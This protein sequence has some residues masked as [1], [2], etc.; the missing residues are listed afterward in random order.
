M[1]RK[2]SNREK[3][4][5]L[6][7]LCLILSFI[8]QLI[9]PNKE[10]EYQDSLEVKENIKVDK[11]NFHNNEKDIILKI[12]NEI[13][14]IVTINYINKDSYIDEYNNQS[15]DI[16]LNISGKIDDILKIEESLKNIGLEKSINKIEIVR[17]TKDVKEENM[18]IINNYVDCI[19][20]IKVV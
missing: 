7:L 19:M 5:G 3:L 17:N 2:L 11:I 10:N 15:T 9:Y 8:I 1:G 20:R 12:E 14:S 16:E 4:L 13:K 18:E 6:I